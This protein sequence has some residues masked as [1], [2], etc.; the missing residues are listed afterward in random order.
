K[1]S[2]ASF[3]RS[4][5]DDSRKARKHMLVM[6]V[7]GTDVRTMKLIE[8]ALN[9]IPDLR[10]YWICYRKDEADTLKELPFAKKRLKICVEADLGLFLFEL[11]QR[12]YLSLPP[13]GAYY[14]AIP[15]VPPGLFRL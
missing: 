6:G 2:F 8:N 11:Y 4:A 12:H 9:A 5:N 1:D 3:F 14:P 15:R 10:V 13:A 7:S